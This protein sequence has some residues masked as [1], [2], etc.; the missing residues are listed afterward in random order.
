VRINDPTH[1]AWQL[2]AVLD[3]D[4]AGRM[5]SLDN[6]LD[7]AA[8][9]VATYVVRMRGELRAR[10]MGSFDELAA[11]DLATWRNFHERAQALID[12]GTVH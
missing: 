7:V 5:A 1:V 2:F 10:G 12:G 11:G 8:I 6:M 9:I 3:D 4:A